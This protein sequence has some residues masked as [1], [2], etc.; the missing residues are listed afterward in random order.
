LVERQLFDEEAEGGKEA[1]DV[2]HGVT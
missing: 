1:V 2:A